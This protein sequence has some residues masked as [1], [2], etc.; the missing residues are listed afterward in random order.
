MW[1][2]QGVNLKARQATARV[3]AAEAACGGK[4]SRLDTS[5]RVQPL[6]IATGNSTPSSDDRHARGQRGPPL[7]IAHEAAEARGER[8]GCPRAMAVAP[9]READRSRR[10][11][12]D[13]RSEE[14][15]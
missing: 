11:R 14:H 7:A 2:S 1:H 15:T 5:S 4:A 10:R 13:Q 8:V 3:R 6:T 12:P 9:E